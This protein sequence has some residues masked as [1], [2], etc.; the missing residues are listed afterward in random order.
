M[1]PGVFAFCNAA[2]SCSSPHLLRGQAG[3]LLRAP[4]RAWVSGM[5]PLGNSNP[6]LWLL[7]L[8]VRD[9]AW[10]LFQMTL[11][12]CSIVEIYV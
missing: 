9:Q 11:Y 8:P 5:S 2:R 6:S 4:A 7:G 10:I 1:E 12:I 3:A